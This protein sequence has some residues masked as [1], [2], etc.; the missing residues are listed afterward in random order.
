[1]KRSFMCAFRG[2]YACIRSEKNFRFHLAMTFYV[3]L[4]ALI[5]RL[6]ETEWILVLLCIGAVTGAEIFN[7]LI[8]LVKDMAAGAVLMFAVTSAAI[9]SIIFFTGDKIS[10][11]LDFA[12]GHILLILLLAASVPAAAYFIFGRYGHD[13]KNSH[14]YDSGSPKRR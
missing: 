13:N 10:R 8:G 14:D 12:G 1:L 3:L 5:T 6:S 11:A 2:A 9:G 4:A 7:K